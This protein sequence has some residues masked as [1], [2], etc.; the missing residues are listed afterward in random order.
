MSD[1]DQKL[2]ACHLTAGYSEPEWRDIWAHLLAKLV[3]KLRQP[4]I[5]GDVQFS[6]DCLAGDIQSDDN[7]DKSLSPSW[8]GRMSATVV[9]KRETTAVEATLFLRA[10]GKRLI[11]IDGFAYVWLWYERLPDGKYDWSDARWM[12]DEFGEYEHWV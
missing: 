3:T 12:K 2:F 11:A 6:P 8:F 10:F 4:I 7:V 5:T 9:A 1:L